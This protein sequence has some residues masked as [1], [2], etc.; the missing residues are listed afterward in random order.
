MKTNQRHPRQLRP[1]LR[2]R[3]RE[4]HIPRIDA[5]ARLNHQA[6]QEEQLKALAKG[7]TPQGREILRK[8]LCRT[9]RLIQGK[10]HSLEQLV[11]IIEKELTMFRALQPEFTRFLSR[12]WGI[13]EEKCRHISARSFAVLIVLRTGYMLNGE[14]SE[15]NE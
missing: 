10:T 11:G 8:I 4:W 2:R 12:T 1:V 6:L 13:N 15:S 14:A 3:R 9:K 7:T 5:A